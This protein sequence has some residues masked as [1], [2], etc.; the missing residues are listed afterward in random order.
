MFST[1][2]ATE[3]W[4]ETETSQIFTGGNR[5]SF[6][7]SILGINQKL[8]KMFLLKFT[9]C[10][11]NFLRRFHR[12]ISNFY[13]KNH[14]KTTRDQHVEI[15]T[16]K[17]GKPLEVKTLYRICYNNGPGWPNV[18]RDGCGPGQI[19]KTPFFL[20]FQQKQKLGIQEKLRLGYNDFSF[21][22]RT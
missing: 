19:E 13:Y 17:L 21:F 8:P 5:F 18:F 2:G 1:S 15:K 22:F 9:F 20:I 14:S 10:P 4:L 16:L 3:T 6:W 12:E 11:K 7:R